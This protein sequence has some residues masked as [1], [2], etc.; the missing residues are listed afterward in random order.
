MATRN[1]CCTGSIMVVPGATVGAAV[2]A[3][4]AGMNLCRVAVAVAAGAGGCVAAG[5]GGCVALGAGAG[6]ACV[7][8]CVAG[9]G[10]A[11]GC[12]AA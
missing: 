3:V 9:T 1:C 10:A 6:A 7:A 8:A 12:G 5:A 4:T 2:V 11:V